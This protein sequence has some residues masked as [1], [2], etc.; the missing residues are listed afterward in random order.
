VFEKLQRKP[1]EAVRA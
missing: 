1:G